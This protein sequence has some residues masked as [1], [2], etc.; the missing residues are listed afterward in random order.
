[1]LTPW[2]SYLLDLQ[3]A[4]QRFWVALGR[5]EAY[6]D[7]VCASPYGPLA[8]GEA[9]AELRIAAA[10]GAATGV[11][12]GGAAA[13]AAGGNARDTT[14]AGEGQGERGESSMALKARGGAPGCPKGGGGGG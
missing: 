9:A 10:R 2:Q 11:A 3:R 4:P 1:M 13:V 14:A 12:A 7:T 5:I 8:L 6:A